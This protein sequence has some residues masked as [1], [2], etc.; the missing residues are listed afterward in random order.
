MDSKN[1]YDALEFN[2]VSK[3]DWK[4]PKNFNTVASQISWITK[5]PPVVMFLESRTKF[6][7]DFAR[8]LHL[9][10]IYLII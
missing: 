10:N 4:T 1:F 3:V 5:I 9:N 6:D 7:K 8:V 2:L